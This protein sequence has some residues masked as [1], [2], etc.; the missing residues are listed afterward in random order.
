MFD[1]SKTLIV[2]YK[3]EM[4]VNQFKKLVE[5]SDYSDEQQAGNMQVDPINIVSW[6]EKVWIGNK[7]AGNI[8]DKIL[9]LGDIKG[10]DKL[11]PV[12]DVKFNEYG[13]KY[14]WAG[15]QA[16]LFADVRAI[17]NNEKYL[18]FLEKLSDSPVPEMIKNPKYPKP[19]RKTNT[20]KREVKNV[21]RENTKKETKKVHD[22]FK[23]AK[24]VMETGTDSFGKFGNK[25][26]HKAGNIFT[27]Q[28][29]V[30]RQM[31]FYG[32]VNFYNEGL[33][34]FMNI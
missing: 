18:D 31:L 13:V 32:I 23:K 10:N 7:K 33:R 12:V 3:D 25:A 27:D 29:R 20:S 15:N 11:I 5:S 30:K 14:G 9:F 21:S 8:K 16:V 4:L 28:S 22:I 17:N 6:T 1:I 34:T 2:V 26:L 19:T 24:S